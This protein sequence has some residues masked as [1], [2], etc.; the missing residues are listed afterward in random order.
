MTEERGKRADDGFLEPR[1]WG[2]GRSRLGR[3]E[4]EGRGR[5]GARVGR[6]EARACIFARRFARRYFASYASEPASSAT[7]G[8]HP[9]AYG[10]PRQRVVFPSPGASS[11][12][13]MPGRARR[14]ASTSACRRSIVSHCA[15]SNRVVASYL[16]RSAAIGASTPAS[17]GMAPRGT[18]LVP[19]RGRRN[20]EMVA[21]KRSTRERQSDPSVATQR[22]SNLNRSHRLGL[23]IAV[24]RHSLGESTIAVHLLMA[25]MRLMNVIS[26]ICSRKPSLK[27]LKPSV[28]HWARTTGASASLKTMRGL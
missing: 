4:R 27:Q 12:V 2:G 22:I 21:T 15:A 25:L 17:V 28:E 9:E 18:R 3:D 19:P 5:E 23:S 20:T 1:S 6:T 8:E 11:S 7:L 26:I 24:T 13:G 14:S 16:A 10:A